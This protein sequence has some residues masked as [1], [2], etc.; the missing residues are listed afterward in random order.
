MEQAKH[1]SE[2]QFILKDNLWRVM[3]RLSWPAVVA[4]VLYGLN[5]VFDAIFVGSFVGKNALAGVSLVYPLTQVTLGIGS[6]IGVGAGSALSIAIGKKDGETQ[7][8]L[9]G[10]VNA[11]CLLFTVVFMVLGLVFTEPLVKMMGG[12][13]EILDIGASY[14]RVTVI[15][16]F[17]WIYGLATNMIVRAE[18]RMKTAAVMMGS[19]LLV[20]IAANY[21]LIVVM[22]FGVKG[23][24]WGTNIGMLVYGICSLAYFTAG[25]ASFEAKPWHVNW[26]GALVKTITGLGMSS[27]IMTVMTLIQGI[28]VLNA[29]SRYGT[30]LDLAFY[31]ALF[32]LFTFLLTPIFGLMRALQPVVGINYGAGDYE[33]VIKSFKVFAGASTLLTL[34]FWSVMMLRPD[35][36]LAT[37]FDTTLLTPALLTNARIFMCL[38]PILP[39]IFMAMTFF[40]AIGDGKPAALLGIGRQFFFYIPVMLL[41]PRLF[42]V[43]WVYIGS[44]LIDIVV[45][46]WCFIMVGGAFKKMRAQAP[47]LALDPEVDYN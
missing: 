43:E 41:L 27:F 35:W 44:T 47:T 8:Q 37:M 30:T 33:R 40:P 17:F 31:G 21:L 22:D 13:G 15:G 25:R 4:M 38:L 6:L 3:F 12:K 11:L 24:A 26:N 34:P 18:G 1:Q 36:A 16:A 39:V 20:N 42:G 2:R 46:L 45:S 10:S 23:A 9:L 29:V 28:V 5:T 32:R 7:R 19:G 14:F